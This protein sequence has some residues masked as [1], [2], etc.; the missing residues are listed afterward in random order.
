MFPEIVRDDVFRIESR[1]LWLRWPVAA[2]AFDAD[3]P[4]ATGLQAAPLTAG[5]RMPGTACIV[6]WRAEA[7]RGE[8][9][10]LVIEEKADGR[11]AVGTVHLAWTRDG[12]LAIDYHLAPHRRGEGL[13]TEAIQAVI[14]TA[15]LLKLAPAITA[16]PL[17]ADRKGRDVLERCGFTYLG[18]GMRPG[19]GTPGL[20]ACDHFRLDRRTWLSLQGWGRPGHGPTSRLGAAPTGFGL[21]AHV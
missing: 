12:S 4:V 14:H 8:A 16:A 18:S 10:H 11:P 5:C 15:F 21:A 2:D 17:A 19:P 7:E 1:R 3:T 6:A 20:T 9:L 13:M